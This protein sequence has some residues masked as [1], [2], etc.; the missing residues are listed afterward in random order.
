MSIIATI[1]S[2]SRHFDKINGKEEIVRD[3]IEKSLNRHYSKVVRQQR[4]AMLALLAEC[5]GGNQAVNRYSNATSVM[6][7]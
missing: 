3:P 4:P 7:L 2:M 1:K 6:D 5:G